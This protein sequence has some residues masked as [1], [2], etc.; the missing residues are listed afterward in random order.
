MALGSQEIGEKANE[1]A[2]S[3][4]ALAK[5]IRPPCALVSLKVEKDD[6]PILVT[7]KMK[8]IMLQKHLK[9]VRGKKGAS[10]MPSYTIIIELCLL[11][12]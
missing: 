3:S 11:L 2:L 6:L 12:G 10:R 5:G 9:L 1:N 4:G 8:E 7:E